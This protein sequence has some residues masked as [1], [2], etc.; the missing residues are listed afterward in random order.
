MFIADIWPKVGQFVVW[1]NLITKSSIL[2]ASLHF[3]GFSGLLFWN[4]LKFQ[5]IH[6]KAREILWHLICNTWG[7]ILRLHE[8]ECFSLTLNSFQ[9]HFLYEAHDH[10]YC[11]PVK[12]NMNRL[13]ICPTVNFLLILVYGFSYLSWFSRNSV[14]LLKKIGL[15][16]KSWWLTNHATNEGS[17][18]F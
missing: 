7:W 4:T 11:Q 6:A 12:T 16:T 5:Q 14:S 3:S 18:S 2:W 13:G 1:D 15:F 9:M 8:W 10:N 17:W